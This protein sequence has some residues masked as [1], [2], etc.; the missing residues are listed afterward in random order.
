MQAPGLADEDIALPKIRMGI[1]AM[2]KK[3]NSK[4]MRA[5]VQRLI[6][7]GEF[8]VELFGDD[9]I[10]NKPV[11]EWPLCDCL[12]SWHSDGFPLHKVRLF[13]GAL[14]S[15]SEQHALASF[16]E[17]ICQLASVDGVSCTLHRVMKVRVPAAAIHA[18]TVCCCFLA[19]P[20]IPCSLPVSVLPR[21]ESCIS[22]MLVYILPPADMPDHC[23]PRSTP[24]CASPTW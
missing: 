21:P 23:R 2:D 5:I 6:A 18:D 19:Q 9:N 10:L 8:E 15:A 7:F 4:P 16:R 24:A 17:S 1:C 14:S 20:S 11:S 3:A 13:V 12:L 22:S